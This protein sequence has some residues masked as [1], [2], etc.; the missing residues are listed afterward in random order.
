MKEKNLPEFKQSKIT[1]LI[2]LPKKVVNIASIFAQD[3]EYFKSLFKEQFAYGHREI[4]LKYCGLDFSTQIIGNLQHGVQVDRLHLRKSDLQSARYF[5]GKKSTFWVFSTKYMQSARYYGYKKVIAIGAPWL[6]LKKSI[7]LKKDIRSKKRILLMPGHESTTHPTRLTADQKRERAANYR[8]IVG[9]SSAIVCLHAVDFLDLEVRDAF[10][11][12]NFNVTCVGGSSLYPV[13]SD[14]ANRIKSLYTLMLLMNESDQLLT[15]RYGTHL[16]YA[17]DMGLDIAIHPNLFNYN[18]MEDASGRTGVLS[19]EELNSGEYRYLFENFPKAIN[20]FTSSKE[21]KEISD[22]VLG[23]D[24]V[25]SASD[26]L[27]VL[28]Y[29]GGIYPI[30]PVQPW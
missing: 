28:E 22:E 30:S 3:E 4:L 21:Y 12:E 6:Y 5:H 9:D 13:W 15:D 17:I 11:A 29:R 2:R 25:L 1:K 19:P 14:A 10:R 18:S 20:E 16:F 24:A 26:L 23:A 8:K 7:T 27:N